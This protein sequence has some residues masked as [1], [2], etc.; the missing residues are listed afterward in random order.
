MYIT[1]IASEFAPIAK[2]G[3]LGDVVSG[4]AKAHQ[5]QGHQLEVILPKYDCILFN[6]IQNLQVAYRDLWTTEGG[7]RY[8]N[9]IWSANYGDITL[10]LIEPHH[11]QYYFNRGSIYGATDDIN[12]FTYFSNAALAFLLH[13]KKSPQVLHLHD[14]PTALVAPLYKD[15]YAQRGLKVGAI[16]FT[17]HN[18]EH[19]GKCSGSVLERWGLKAENYLIPEKMQDPF[20]PLLVNLLKGAIVYADG[21]NT[22]SPTYEK[23]IQTAEGGCGLQETLAKYRSKIRGI[24]N[25]IDESYWNPSTDSF[26]LHSYIT[27]PPLTQEKVALAFAAKQ[28]NKKE[29]LL[30]LG[31]TSTD[32]PLVISI[33]RLATQKGPEL[34]LHGINRTLEKGGQFILLGS[35]AQ[36]EILSLF[37]ALQK[38]EEKNKNLAI[39]F[40]HDESL[41]HRLYAAADML[42]VPSLFEPCGL[43]QMIAM[44]YGTV[45]IVRRTGGLADTVFDVETSS[46]PTAQ[47]NGFSF[48]YP[49]YAGVDWALDRA[50]ALYCD[51]PTQWQLLASQGMQY[52][53]SWK[54][55]AKEYLRYYKEIGKTDRKSKSSP[56]K[57]EKEHS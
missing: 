37:V 47:K 8:N 16:A 11:P 52:D 48:D 29:L 4:L 9:T 34:I 54:K 55:S 20:S 18:L 17:I 41:A 32:K 5:S 43:T 46:V 3:G 49:D 24:L 21:I 28:N 51:H 39:I 53:F 26:L 12:R 44:R 40:E 22:V 42:L 27:H 15:L 57:S 10:Y 13:A 1:H 14:W 35:L 25:G 6:Q 38:R 2:A 31:L 50:I 23:E 36:P 30:S 33:T 19:Q 7:Q 56:A 45:P